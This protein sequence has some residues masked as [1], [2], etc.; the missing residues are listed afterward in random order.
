MIGLM[1]PPVAKQLDKLEVI[2]KAAQTVVAMSRRGV[3]IADR[4][5]NSGEQQIGF[6]QKAQIVARIFDAAL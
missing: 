1:P 6:R 2:F 3:D 5:K 4:A